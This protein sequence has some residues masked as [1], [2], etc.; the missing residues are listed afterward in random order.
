MDPLTERVYAIALK[1]E[2]NLESDSTVVVVK[3]WGMEE[4]GRRQP[5]GQNLQLGD[6]V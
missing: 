2:I 5:K 1:D 4:M 3:G 6:K